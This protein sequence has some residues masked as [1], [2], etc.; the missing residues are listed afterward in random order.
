MPRSQQ[1]LTFSE[2]RVGIFML[3][4]LVLTGF[5]ILNSTGNFNP[6]EKKMR[7]KARFVSADGLHPGAD[8]QLAGVSIGKVEDVKFIE[9]EGDSEDRIEATLNIVRELDRKPIAE[10][11][12]SDS[13]AQLVATS[14]LGNDKMINVV[15]GSSKGSPIGENAV[16]TSSSGIGLNQLTATGNKL[17]EQINKLAL[18]ANEILNKANSGEGT[19]GRII[20]DEALYKD[21]DGAVAETKSTM[22][23]LQTT[24]DK[25]NSGEGSAGKL[26]NDPALYD[27]L[28][29]TVSQLEAISNDIKT[30]RGSAG[31]FLNDEALYNETRDT[32]SELRKSAEKISSIAD[33]VKLITADLKDGKGTAG[34]LFKDEKLYEDARSAIARF[35]GAT[36]RIE[37]LIADA[38]AGKGT[39]GKLI[40]DETLF[41]NLNVTS[42]NIATFTGEGT[43][44]LDDFRKNPKKYL[45]IK[46]AIF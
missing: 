45:R 20:N 29:R 46:L 25:I 4:T 38:Q 22:L 36:T 5:L 37:S 6:F 35:N 24:I 7:L 2:L 23:R 14:I 17:F 26:V 13:T 10:L 15:P 28:N 44:L 31:K 34:K 40:T 18:P 11:I 41:N 1:K 16:L 8:V 12:R 39:I 27:S 9:P 21:L 43:K 42:S 30:G 19:L 32:V 3:S 33:D